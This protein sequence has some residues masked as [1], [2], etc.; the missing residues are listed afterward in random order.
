MEQIATPTFSYE[1]LSRV[2]GCFSY[3]YIRKTKGIKGEDRILGALERFCRTEMQFAAAAVV[4][5]QL[6]STDR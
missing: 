2:V 3:S 1:Q 5:S 6:E 4:E